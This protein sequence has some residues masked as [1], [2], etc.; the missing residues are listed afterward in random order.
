MKARIAWHALTALVTLNVS[1]RSVLN[2]GTCI[3][4]GVPTLWGSGT[5]L[6]EFAQ[7]S[8]TVAYAFRQVMNL[9]LTHIFTFPKKT[10]LFTG[11]NAFLSLFVSLSFGG[12]R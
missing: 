2:A 12:A 1:L 3:V 4:G 8:K 10:A 6:P 9:R 7:G 5:F 11:M